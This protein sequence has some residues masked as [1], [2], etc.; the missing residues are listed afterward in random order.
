MALYELFYEDKEPPKASDFSQR[1][2]SGKLEWGSADKDA[3]VLTRFR[4]LLG[5]LDAPDRRLLFFMAQRVA[6]R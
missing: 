6:R 4:R 2:S 3:R 1:R 5:K